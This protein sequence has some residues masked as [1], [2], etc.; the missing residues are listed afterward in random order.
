MKRVL[1]LPG[2]VPVWVVLQVVAV[3]LARGSSGVAVKPQAC[4][5]T[6]LLSTL[7]AGAGG[8]ISQ[9]H[10]SKV[11]VAHLGLAYN[12]V[13]LLQVPPNNNKRASPKR[14]LQEQPCLGWD[15]SNQ[16]AATTDGHAKLYRGRHK[17]TCLPGGLGP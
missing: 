16:T 12:T 13:Q 17:H 1:A 5:A 10:N 9:S 6:A 2:C 11:N 14:W 3:A 15:I 8:S 7:D 4:Q